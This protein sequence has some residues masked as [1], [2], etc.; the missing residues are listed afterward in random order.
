MT[1]HFKFQIQYSDPNSNARLGSFQT[2]HGKFQTPI[3]MPVGT[4]ATVKGTTPRA[5]DEIGAEIILSN[6]YHLY[7]RPGHQLIQKLGGLHKFMGWNK[8]ILTDSGGFQ[9]FSQAQ[10]RKISDSGVS[11]RSYLDGSKH[12]FDPE[13][14]IQIQEALG[15][16]IIMAFDECPPLPSSKDQLLKAVQRTTQWLQRCIKAKTRDDQ[17]LFGI[18][19]G[20]TDLQLRKQHLEEIASFDLPGYALGGLSVGETPEEMYEVVQNIVPLM[21]KDKPR[22]LMGVGYPWDIAICVAA[23]IDMFDC[24]LPTRNARNGLLFTS[25]GPVKIRNAKYAED[26]EPLDPNC[27]CYTCQN[28]SKA[29]LRHLFKAEEML[30]PILATHHNLA[31]YLNL[32][33]QIRNAIREGTLQNLIR[34]L[35][36][37]KPKK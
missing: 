28:F 2:P 21:P 7:L 17:A 37:L 5:L 30:G 27:H 33:K 22:Y 12:W 15:A 6:T 31:Y 26:P 4:A 23:G 34:H 20:G 25:Q 3:F 1:P 10:L 14:A 13:K 32:I 19:Q 24:V 36:D 18:V 16:D 35:L 29:Y 9:V 11:F 8:P